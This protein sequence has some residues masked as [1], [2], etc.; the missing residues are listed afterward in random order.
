MKIL[1]TLAMTA[2]ATAIVAAASPSWAENVIRWSR[3][4]DALT[5][6]P[7]AANAAPTLNSAH[8]VYDSLFFLNNDMEIVPWLATGF[9]LKDATTWEF[10]IRQGVRFHDGSMLTAG[11]VKF[12]LERALS[13]NSDLKG[14]I[15]S[16]SVV[17]V[18]D[19][20]T[21][22][23]TTDG[24]SPILPNLLANI[25]I[26][27]E[28]WAKE[29]GVEQPQDRSGGEETY[30]VRNA[31]G[32]GP[33]ILE[34]REPDVRTVMVKNPDWWGLAD[35][36][37]EVDKLVFTPIANQATRIAA[38]LS[39]ELDFVIDPP[40]QDLSRI[41]DTAGYGLQTAP[42]IRTIFLGM[43]QYADELKSSNV[44]GANPFQDI[45][46]RR[47]MYQAINIEAIQ[48]KIMRGFSVPAG[49]IQP[50]G[51]HG[52]SEALDERLPYDLDAAKSL[53]EEAGYPDGF[54]VQLDCPNDRYI[55]DE[56]ICQAVVGMLA[57]IGVNANL[58]AI[59]KS[60]HFPL[61]GNRETDFYMLGW[62]NSSLDSYVPLK[63]QFHTEDSGWNAGGYSNARMDE[64]IEAIATE[65]DFDKRDAMIA[66]AW[67]ISVDDV[68]YLPLHHQ[69]IAWAMSD[70][71]SVPIAGDNFVRFHNATFK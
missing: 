32:T 58:S 10:S 70:N 26:M 52:Y 54:S 7:H 17:E 20:A 2:A 45:R 6:D 28:A 27:S 38:L 3:A 42:Q 48:D 44:E 55:N 8:L 49:M 51:V 9:E 46:V 40:V 47:A 71:V 56:A 43:N 65:T 29:H 33:F 22:R 53:M 37:H 23:V 31:M 68:V 41:E 30:A 50:P 63:F 57:K 34:S 12:S 16:I 36:P 21:V 67:Q 35:N 19:D 1:R 24:P 69:V 4:G 11:D 62:G 25:M 39:G 60:Q 66:E 13:E 59:T 61:I 18:V 64:L 5:A 14:D 15:A